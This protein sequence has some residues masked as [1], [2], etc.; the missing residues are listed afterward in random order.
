MRARYKTLADCAPD[1]QPECF[2]CDRA[3]PPSTKIDVQEKYVIAHC[4]FCR[5]MTPFPRTFS[6]AGP[7]EI[8]EHMAMRNRGEL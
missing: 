8:A 2:H 6:E 7:K 3:L 5:C 1:V 4:P